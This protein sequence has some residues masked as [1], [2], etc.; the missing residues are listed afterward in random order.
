MVKRNRSNI[1]FC[2]RKCILEFTMGLVSFLWDV[3]SPMWTPK[4]ISWREN[5]ILTRFL[6]TIWS[7]KHTLKVSING[8]AYM[9][10]IV[11]IIAKDGL[12]RAAA[13]CTNSF[14]SIKKVP[15][16]YQKGHA[17]HSISEHQ[18]LSLWGWKHALNHF[19]PFHA[20]RHHT[21]LP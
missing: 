21:N 12:S 2:R 19:N 6:D 9:Y 8:Y 17:F 13:M 5:K 18:I 1:F 16:I 7:P 3:T 20:A 15:I 14:V 11:K 4:C 10:F